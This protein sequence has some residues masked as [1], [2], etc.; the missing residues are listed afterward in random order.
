MAVASA[1]G[2]VLS[3][4]DPERPWRIA[5][6]GLPPGFKASMLQSLEKGSITEIDFINGAVVRW[7]D[8]HGV[9]TPVNRTLVA[10]IKG[11]ERA[12]API[13]ARAPQA[14]ASPTVGP[15]TT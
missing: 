11:A 3:Y 4:D 13:H 2:I 7:G 10:A 5:G 14:N 8:R 9:P 15:G 6:E 12:L 1:A